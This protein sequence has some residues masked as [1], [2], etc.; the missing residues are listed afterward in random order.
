[1]KE[2]IIYEKPTC[3]TCRVAVSLVSTSGRPYKRIRYHE[4]PLTKDALRDLVRKLDMRPAQ[5]VRTKEE[6]Y[7]QLQVDVASLDDEAVLELLVHYPELMERPILE[8]GDRA[9][10]G[11]P[12]ERVAPFLDAIR[13]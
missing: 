2:I 10:L 8:Y 3:S 6:R 5:I 1:M 11:R 7:R 13:D 4:E 9:I 12:T